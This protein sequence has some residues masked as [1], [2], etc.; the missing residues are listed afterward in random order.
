[1]LTY[2]SSGIC[3]WVLELLHIDLY[4]KSGVQIPAKH[5]GDVRKPMSGTIGPVDIPCLGMQ[6][7]K[8]GTHYC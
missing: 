1:M 4:E 3:S 8:E 6:K 7:A 5:S 2:N